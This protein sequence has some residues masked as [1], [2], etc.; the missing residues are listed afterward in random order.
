MGEGKR[1]VI[2]VKVDY[3]DLVCGEEDQL[4]GVF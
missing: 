4:L 3:G 2:E 1:G